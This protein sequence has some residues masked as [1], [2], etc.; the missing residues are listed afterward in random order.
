MWTEHKVH[1][2]NLGSW[3]VMYL[4]ASIH[5]C[6]S[7]RALLF[8]TLALFGIGVDCDLAYNGM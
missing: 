5:P 6:V 4:V 1:Y 8:E 7:V 3:E 2:N